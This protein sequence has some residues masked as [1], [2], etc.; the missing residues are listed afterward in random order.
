MTATLLGLEGPHLS[1]TEGVQTKSVIQRRF[2]AVITKS[3]REEVIPDRRRP[4]IAKQQTRLACQKGPVPNTDSKTVASG[5][6]F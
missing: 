2:H 1:A 4:K 6:A 3:K 5:A